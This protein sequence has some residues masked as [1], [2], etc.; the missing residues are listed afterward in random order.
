MRSMVTVSKMDLHHS[1]K[2]TQ[3][4]HEFDSTEIPGL[5]GLRRR[6]L[7]IHQNIQIHLYDFAEKSDQ[8]AL[9]KVKSDPRMA[10]LSVDLQPFVTPY[11]PETW[12]SPADSA[13]SCF[14][15]WE[16]EPTEELGSTGTTVTLARIAPEVIPDITKIVGEFDA[17]TQSAWIRRRQLFAFKDLCIQVQDH[18]G[19]H[20]ADIARKAALDLWNGQVVQGLP[21][22]VARE[23]ATD[24]HASRIY[25]WSAS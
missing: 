3:L 2:V 13:A 1:W 10:R 12:N 24:G 19:S 5:I 8:I 16:G 21:H 25:G 15:C 11:E 20:G 9:E 23:M 22:P 17:T 7:F 18:A 14:Y 6:Q 4:F